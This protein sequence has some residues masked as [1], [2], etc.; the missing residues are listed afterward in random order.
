MKNI[1]IT[2]AFLIGNFLVMPTSVADD[3]K[4]KL[5][6]KLF[7]AS[8]IIPTG[9]S[10]VLLTEVPEGK[11]LTV[12][13]FCKNGGF[14][15]DLIGSELGR[16]IAEFNTVCTTYVPGVLFKGGQSIS[17]VSEFGPVFQDQVCLING[18]I[19]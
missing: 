8:A 7:S 12:T 9:S 14:G 5:R 17:C 4:F 11:S 16:V 6:G 10:S 2:V 1:F 13:Q 18:V 19:R 15:P 3:D